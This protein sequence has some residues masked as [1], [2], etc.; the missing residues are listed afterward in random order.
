MCYVNL[1]LD[2]N[3]DNEF[4]KDTN[5]NSCSENNNTVIKHQTILE[6]GANKSS[7]GILW[8]SLNGRVSFHC[9]L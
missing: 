3:M 9:N 4:S 5:S 1:Q 6:K 2:T 8:K 7:D